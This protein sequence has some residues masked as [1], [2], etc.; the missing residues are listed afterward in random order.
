MTKQLIMGSVT[1]VRVRP[2][3]DQSV[4]ISAEN[5]LYRTIDGGLTWSVIGQ[6]SFVSQ[7]ISAWEIAYAPDN[8]DVV[9]AA[10]SQGL[11]RSADGGDNFTE[12][13]PN[14]CEALAFKPGDPQTVY[15]IHF[16]SSVG[17][18]RFY[19]SIDGGQTFEQSVT[20]WFDST[21]GDI[22]IQGGR[23][24]VTEADP[25]RIYACLV[26]YQNDGS[27]VTTNGWVG[28]WVSYDSGETWS[29]PH[30][31]IGTPYTNEHPNLMNFQ[32][33][34]GDYSQIHYNTTMIASQLDADKI[35]IGG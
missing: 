33:N 23:L 1:A 34:D 26:G 16:D 19:K 7:N 27:S 15:A 3:D 12:I 24:A 6:P 25:N 29:L 5:D 17:Y 18:A 31:L 14:R 32:G 11:F 22:D 4:I 30:G 9:F 21:M 2:S 28:T 13:L 8:N 10:T 35:L 20:G